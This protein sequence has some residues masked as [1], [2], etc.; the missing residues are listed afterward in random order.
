MA[1]KKVVESKSVRLVA[2]NGAQVTV[3]ADSADQYKAK[4]YKG[5]P[6]RPAKSESGK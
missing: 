3:S 2:P 6:G 4:G 1:S 5:V